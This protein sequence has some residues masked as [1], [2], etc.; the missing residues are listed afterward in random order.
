MTDLARYERGQRGAAVGLAAYIGLAGLKLGVG[1][2]SG[3]R[4]LVADGINN[5]TDIAGTLAV[6]L[7]MRVAGR[8]ADADHQYGHQRAETLATVIVS[9]IMATVAVEIGLGA[10]RALLDPA[11][12]A[13]RPE[14]AWAAAFG[15]LVMVAVWQYN[16]RL[17]RRL[18]SPALLAAAADHLSDA[19]SSLVALAGVAGAELGLPWLDPVAGLV[20]AGFILRTAWE[21]GREGAHQL[22]DGFDAAQL[23]AIRA[24]VAEVEGVA[25]V[26]D[27]RAR[28][29]GP[30]VL[31]DVTIGVD[32]NLTVA[33]GHGVAER[34][35]SHLRGWCA[36][37]RV[38][39]HVEPAPPPVPSRR[40]D[41]SPVPKEE[42]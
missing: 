23:E 36:I 29:M 19:L 12:A 20:V 6:L 30:A 1:F 34:V 41:G 27:V 37:D 7:A 22:L 9:G 14:A 4:A 16:L 3:S 24:R 2:W 10:V 40:H 32:R 15:A 11:R 8:P 25:A 17:G 13:P 33:E 39:V 28:Y 42:A 31:V 18:G 38:M 5:L 21:I 26:Y 35:E